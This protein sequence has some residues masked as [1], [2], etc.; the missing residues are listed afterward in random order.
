MEIY[1]VYIIR[2]NTSGT[3]Y[4]GYTKNI[5]NRLKQHNNGESRF[6]RKMGPW[7]L[8]YAEKCISKKEARIREKTDQTIQQKIPRMAMSTTH[9][10]R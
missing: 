7:S 1:Y 2:C 5:P 9:Q 6:T 10:L 4:K 8:I 3:L